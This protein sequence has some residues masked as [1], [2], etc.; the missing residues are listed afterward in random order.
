MFSSGRLSTETMMMKNVL[1][2]KM[3]KNFRRLQDLDEK[4]FQDAFGPA[5]LKR[6]RNLPTLKEI[7]YKTSLVFGN[8]HVSTGE[9]HKLPQNYISVLGYHID[10]EIKPLSEVSHRYD[11]MILPLT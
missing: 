5:A 2:S 4:V 8:S 7:K 6:G 1:L 10:D 3:F 11:K 9:A